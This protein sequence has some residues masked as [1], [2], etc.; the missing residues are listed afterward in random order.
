MMKLKNNKKG[1]ALL[2]PVL[3]ILLGIGLTVGGS[4][5]YNFFVNEGDLNDYDGTII[6]GDGE[7]VLKS[8][9]HVTGEDTG[10][11]LGRDEPCEKGVVAQNQPDEFKRSCKTMLEK[12][13][14]ELWFR[15][16]DRDCV[17]CEQYYQS[18]GVL[19]EIDIIGYDTKEMCDE[20]KYEPFG[21]DENK[22]VVINSPDDCDKLEEK[23]KCLNFLDYER[24]CAKGKLDPTDPCPPALIGGVL[25]VP[26]IFCMLK[27]KF[28]EIFTPLFIGIAIIGGLIAWLISF[29][30]LSSIS[31][32]KKD[33]IVILVASLIIGLVIGY[34][35]YAFRYVGLMILVILVI[36]RGLYFLRPLLKIE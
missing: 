30:L 5:A 8:C 18:N 21:C 32:K 10:G 12:Y 31:N 16:L 17:S 26:D 23:G 34:L 33:K 6:D 1:I 28:S 13:D 3:F 25:A 15:T 19:P 35:L 29:S 11:F 27:E 2:F 7:S 9:A 4:F 36:T 24:H 14:K 22:F 20:N